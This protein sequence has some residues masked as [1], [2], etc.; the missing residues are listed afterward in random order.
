MSILYVTEY[1]AKI[2]T[3]EGRIRVVCNN[4][5]LCS[6]PVE[7]VESITI[8]G[9]VSFTSD[10]IK[11]CLMKGISVDYMSKGGKY[12]GRMISNNHVNTA[13]QRAQA[14][15]YQ[16]DFSLALAREIEGA[17]IHNQ[18]VIMFRCET[19]HGMDFCDQREQ[20]WKLGDKVQVS[21][22]LPE[23]L[24]YEGTAAK[25]YFKAVSSCLPDEFKF[26]RRSRRPP[27]DPFNALISM[28]YSIIFNEIYARIEAR[29]LNAFFGFLHQDSEKHPTLVSDL[30]EEWRPVLIDS[31]VISMIFKNEVKT[32]YFEY[33]SSTGGV[34]LSKSCLSMFLKK[35]KNRLDCSVGYLSPNG[36]E[37]SYRQLIDY[38]VCSLVRAIEKGDSSLYQAVRIR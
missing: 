21:K 3:A 27:L 10:A 4:E 18:N 33:D 20:L 25:I 12:F 23:L 16:T 32:D 38:Q 13:R 36:C 35:I 26:E 34:Y 6:V 37:M 31:L 22:T 7:N 19:H 24:G 14:Y 8:L 2:C 28:G 29:G 15:L 9:A 30:I 17:K 1:G 5:E 11:L